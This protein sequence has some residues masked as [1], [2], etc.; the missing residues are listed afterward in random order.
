MSS[1]ASETVKRYRRLIPAHA[2]V[3][4]DTVGEF[5]ANAALLND[6]AAWG[7]RFDLA[8]I[9]AAAHEIEMTP[10]LGDYQSHEANAITSQ[11]DGGLQRQYAQPMGQTTPE[12][13]RY[14]RLTLYGLKLLALR[15]GTAATLPRVFGTAND[16][17]V[18]SSA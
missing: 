5:I 4:A 3:D 16:A 2:H 11:G 13:D 12:A 1:A 9:Y 10:G 6:E 7:D 8:M 15:D 17:K 18:G 14:Y